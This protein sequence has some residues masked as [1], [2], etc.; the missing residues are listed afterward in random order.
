MT[1]EFDKID[2]ATL[3]RDEDSLTSNVQQPEA[4]GLR[5]TAGIRHI[6]SS[7]QTA[8][9]AQSPCFVA[10]CRYC[11]RG[12]PTIAQIESHD[13]A[14]TPVAACPYCGEHHSSNSDIE[15]HLYQCDEFRCVR[16]ELPYPTRSP[17]TRF[18]P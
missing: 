15:D 12:F 10:Q 9:N 18:A 4:D 16:S 3:I 14:E 5:E 11:Q 7:D 2:Q 6:D 8:Q 17:L 1:D 13:C